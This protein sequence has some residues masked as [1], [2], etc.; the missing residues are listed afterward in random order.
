M[1]KPSF[2]IT[3]SLASMLPPARLCLLFPVSDAKF[4]LSD[5]QHKT[6]DKNH[7]RAALTAGSGNGLNKQFKKPM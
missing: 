4:D 2:N 6:L 5:V 7:R 1:Y 3:S